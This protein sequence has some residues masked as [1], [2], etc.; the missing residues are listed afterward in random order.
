V[1][2]ESE[3]VTN[4][5]D[6]FSGSQSFKSETFVSTRYILTMA[7]KKEVE[8]L[9]LR[10]SSDL[11]KLAEMLGYDYSGGQLQCDNGAFASS[12]LD[13]FDDNP[14]AMIAVQE[15]VMKHGYFEDESEENP[16]ACPG[17]GCLPC[18]GITE[19]CNHPDGC[20]EGKLLRAE[21]SQD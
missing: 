21:S 19:S 7:S 15:W 14:G 3:S 12:L 8:N 18:D 11:C 6:P 1:T 9:P 17:C 2:E 10:T 13:F 5:W 20:G 4:D 16:D